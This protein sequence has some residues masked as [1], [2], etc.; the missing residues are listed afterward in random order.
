M[1]ELLPCPF[2]GNSAEIIINKSKEGQT[3]TVHCSVCSCRKSMLKYP[4]YDGDIEQ[5]AIDDWNTRK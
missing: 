5:D 1:K 4:N 2:C 3:S